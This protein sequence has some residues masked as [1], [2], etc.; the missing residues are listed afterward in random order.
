MQGTFFLYWTDMVHNHFFYSSYL[1]DV[2]Y[3]MDGRETQRNI[4]FDFFVIRQ[5]C[6]FITRFMAFSMF[7]SISIWTSCYHIQYFILHTF[8]PV[9]NWFHLPSLNNFFSWI[10]TKS[11]LKS[12][13]SSSLCIN[14][15]ILVVFFFFS[16]FI[17]TVHRLCL[18]NI[19]V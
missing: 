3:W 12:L 2:V 17:A 13:V 18:L 15:W 6:R 19:L 9:T 14:V 5:I 7:L 10:F 8:V 11:R 1:L 4:W 16:R